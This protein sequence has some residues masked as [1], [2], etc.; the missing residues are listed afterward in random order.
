M[1]NVQFRMVFG[2]TFVDVDYRQQTMDNRK[3]TD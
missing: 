3:E 1:D 2:M